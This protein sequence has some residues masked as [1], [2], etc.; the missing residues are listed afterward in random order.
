VSGDND[1]VVLETNFFEIT[2]I[3]ELLE[4]FATGFRL[5]ARVGREDLH[6]YARR[7]VEEILRELKVFA[8]PY[9]ADDGDYI[10]VLGSQIPEADIKELAKKNSISLL[11]EFEGCVKGLRPRIVATLL[12]EVYDHVLT[13]RYGYYS[14]RP[15]T[16][17]GVEHKVVQGNITRYRLYEGFYPEG[18]S[19]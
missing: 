15:G 12:R 11:K 17:L 10:Y 1:L 19:V 4:M 7:L 6:R 18:F 2:N 5:S 9:V 16:Y 13:Y 8:F 3:H 14:V